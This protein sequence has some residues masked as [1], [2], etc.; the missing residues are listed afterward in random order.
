[1][2]EK[3]RNIVI[4]QALN[5]IAVQAG[6][7]GHDLNAGEDFG[8]LKRHAAGHDQSDIAGTEN[9]DTPPGHESFQIDKTLCCAGRIDSRAP[10]SGRAERSARPFT[11]AHGKDHSF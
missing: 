11:A 4:L 6:G 8:S 2:T 5:D 1:M 7:I 10:G 9:N 3:K